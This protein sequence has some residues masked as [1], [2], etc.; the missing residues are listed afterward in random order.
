MRTIPLLVRDWLSR[1][2]LKHG[3]RPEQNEQSVIVMMIAVHAGTCTEEKVWRRKAE[4]VIFRSGRAICF[5][6][7]IRFRVKGC[8]NNIRETALRQ[9]QDLF[10]LPGTNECQ[11]RK[12]HSVCS[13]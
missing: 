7:A 13:E 4:A 5:I 2:L 1:G 11:S 8:W 12:Q 3:P 10:L 6:S 9:K